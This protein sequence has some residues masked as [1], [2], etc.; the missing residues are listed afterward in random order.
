MTELAE[1]ILL[2]DGSYIDGPLYGSQ[3]PRIWTAPPRHVEIEGTCPACRD[4]EYPDTGCGNYLSQ[5]LLEWAP[6]IGYELDPWQQ[7]SL[8]ESLG[9]KP[10]GKWSAKEVAL[11]VSRQ[12]G[13]GGILEVR[14]LGGLFVLGEE[15]II[16]TAH[17]FKTSSE[18][19]RR[20]QGTI[21]NNPALRKRIK[22]ISTSHGQEGIELRPEPTL[23]FGAGSK[24]VYK[25]LAPRLQFLARSR[26]SGRGFSCD[27]LVYDEAMILSD[28]MVGASMPTM[29]ARANPQI[30]YTAS[31]GLRDSVQL[32][33]VRRRIVK[34]A[35]NLFGAEWSILPHNDSCPRDEFRGRES[36]DFIVCDKHDDR[37]DPRSVAK[38]NPALGYRISLEFTEMERAGMP[39]REHDRERLGVGEWPAEDEAWE[40]ISQEAWAKMTNP[41]PGAPLMPIAFAA[42]IAED[43]ASAT[44]SAA[45]EKPVTGE[46]RPYRTVIEIPQGCSRQG[47]AWV[48]ERLKELDAQ[49]RPRAIGLPKNGPGAALLQDG[50]K[51]WPDRVIA[52]GSAEE[53]AA[54]A[55]FVQQVRDEAFWHFG[56]E[57]APTL[58]H[59]VGRATTR[60]VGDGGKAWSRRDSESDITPITSA[61]AAAYVLNK[62]RRSYDPLKSVA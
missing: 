9:T 11:I 22:S 62:M 2:P 16:H 7:W 13:K 54:F 57:Q 4:A 41:E 37:D 17:Q 50:I 51:L 34:D 32:G 28:E 30:W 23:I 27:C 52:L 55:W 29:A 3:M 35:R 43:G 25:K 60:V 61:T 40:V 18:H 10:N 56:K 47:S 44:I 45:W 38:A 8:T 31:A 26:A 5:D 24:Q 36:N 58:W 1:A 21:E 20:I 33:T 53:A 46:K 59:A 39:P 15:L 6:T 14:E 42:D 19:F 12:N 48:L 49:W